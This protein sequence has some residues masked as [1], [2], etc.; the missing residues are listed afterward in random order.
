MAEI[1]CVPVCSEC[2]QIIFEKVYV[3]DV[4]YMFAPGAAFKVCEIIPARCPKCGAKFDAIKIPE[5]LPIDASNYL[6]TGVYLE[7]KR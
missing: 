5:K 2:R 3:D 6:E 4:P 7:G 1:V